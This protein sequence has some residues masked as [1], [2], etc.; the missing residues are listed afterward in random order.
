MFNVECNFHD[1][2]TDH[3]LQKMTD[4]SGEGEG[5]GVLLLATG[6]TLVLVAGELLFL[7]LERATFFLLVSGGLANLT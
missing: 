4:L 2:S 6:L 3:P 5:D 7:L 1:F